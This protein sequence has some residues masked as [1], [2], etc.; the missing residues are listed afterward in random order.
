VGYGTSLA[1]LVTEFLLPRE[2]THSVFLYT[3]ETN[4][5]ARQSALKAGFIESGYMPS[6]YYKV[7][8]LPP[9]KCVLYVKK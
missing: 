2:E 8:G 3:F 6:S 7:K 5:A 9:D 1:L 4:K